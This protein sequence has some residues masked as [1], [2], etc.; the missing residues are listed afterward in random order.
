[1]F[2]RSLT[3]AVPFVVAC[4]HKWLNRSAYGSCG[5]G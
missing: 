2:R 4:G 1:L 3:P 5:T